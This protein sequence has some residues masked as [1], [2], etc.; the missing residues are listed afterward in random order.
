MNYRIRCRLD[1]HMDGVSGPLVTAISSPS[2]IGDV[3]GWPYAGGFTRLL[4][5]A[6]SHLKQSEA[7]RLTSDY[8]TCDFQPLLDGEDG[9]QMP[10]SRA[11]IHCLQQD[12]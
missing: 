9:T 1:G 10:A 3:M 7:I 8:G 12:F 4:D 11:T 2:E 6:F 5:A